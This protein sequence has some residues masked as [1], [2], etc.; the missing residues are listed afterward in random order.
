MGLFDHLFK[1]KPEAVGEKGG[2]AAAKQPGDPGDNHDPQADPSTFL[3]PKG[4][5]ASAVED[6]IAPVPPAS[7]R[8]ME[9]RPIAAPPQD[10]PA[11]EVVLTLGDILPRIPTHYLSTG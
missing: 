4:Y 3:Q 6:P 1:P 2:E 11:A 5:G 9:R 10:E 8:L 7:A